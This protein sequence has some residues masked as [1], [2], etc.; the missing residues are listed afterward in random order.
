MNDDFDYGELARRMLARV[1]AFFLTA[2]VC[3]LVGLLLGGCRS[4]RYVG[5]PEYHE[6]VKVRTDSVWVHDSVSL[7]VRGDTVFRDKYTTKYRWR[8]VDRVRQDTLWRRDSVRVPVP[9]E[10]RLGWWEQAK[11]DYFMPMVW[12]C[13]IL[14]LSLLWIIRKR[15][16]ASAQGGNNGEE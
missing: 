12:A 8:Y 16:N 11:V 10:R 3:G 1:A 7:V 15:R 13:V 4:V 6:V 5:V 9:V 14:L 2:L